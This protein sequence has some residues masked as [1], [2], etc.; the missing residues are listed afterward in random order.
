MDFSAQTEY[1]DRKWTGLNAAGQVIRFNN[2]YNCHFVQCNFHETQMVECRFKNCIFIR[3]DLSLMSVKDC[4]FSEA[5]FED[6]QLSGV[7]W[8]EAVW[9]K[10]GVLNSVHFTNCGLNYSTFFGI[11]LRKMTLTCCVAKDVDFGESDLTGANC[12]GTDFTDSRFFHTNL[13]EADFTGATNY[14]ISASVNTLKKTRFSLPEAMSLL[15]SLDIVL[16]E[17]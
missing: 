10:R 6:S 2:F 14:R 9:D 12:A 17:A 11:T 8:S 15:Y 5:R 7:N 1:D 3:C 13:T 4:S 16:V